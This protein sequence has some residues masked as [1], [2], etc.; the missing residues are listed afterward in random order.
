M[1]SLK[2]ALGKN[3]EREV[4]QFLENHGLYKVC[5]NFRCRLGEIDLIMREDKILVFVEVR[6]RLSGAGAASVDHAKQQR[7]IKTAYYYLQTHSLLDKCACRFDVVAVTHQQ[8]QLVFDWIKN[9]FLAL[10]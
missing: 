6:Y 5:H 10:E 4:C 2:I 1:P 7:L 8:Q 9:A 3:I